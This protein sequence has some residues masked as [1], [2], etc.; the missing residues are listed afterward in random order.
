MRRKTILI[1]YYTRYVYPLRDTIHTHIY[2]WRHY[3]RH[4]ALFVNLAF[5]FPEQLIRRLRIDAIVF[6]TIF[7]GARENRELFRFRVNQIR[8]LAALPCVKIALPQD[9]YLN[10]DLL[11]DFINEFGVTHLFTVALRPDWKTIYNRIDHQRV[12]IRTVLTGYLDERTL[13]RIERMKRNGHVREIDIGYRAWRADYRLGEFA[14]H[15][16][17]VGEVFQQAAE[18]RG[19]RT[20]ISQRLEDMYAGDAWFA[21]LLCCRATVG[22]EGGA[23]L[24]DRDGA[25]R[26]RAEVYLR[27]HP[28]A[29]F[30]QVRGACFKDD[31]HSIGLMVLSPRHLEAV[32]TETCQF[33]VEGQYNDILKPGVHFFPVRRDYSNVAEALDF[34]QDANRCRAMAAAAYRDIVLSGRWTYRHFVEDIERTV[35]DPA[36]AGARPTVSWWRRI[37]APLSLQLRDWLTWRVIEWE[38]KQRQQPLRGWQRR[39]LE[40]LQRHYPRWFDV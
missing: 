38:L 25:V 2:C 26:D 32:A 27:Q 33:L 28:H 10:T 21:H 40:H 13:R 17:R 22:V 12:H 1:L 36:P 7:L 20:D 14:Q 18:A 37:L 39:W 16:V 30:E 11:N 4:R 15:K 34:L 24:L 23:S 8:S 35:I 19:L 29:S 9:E 3:S 5:G 31:D 6:H